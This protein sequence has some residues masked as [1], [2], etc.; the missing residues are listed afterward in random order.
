MA[1]NFD[2]SVH[3]RVSVKQREVLVAL[4]RKHDVSMSTA[5]RWMIDYCK[6]KP[7]VLDEVALAEK[8]GDVVN[9]IV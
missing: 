7:D 9:G 2:L 3:T 4:A 1:V 8:K 6:D 5:L